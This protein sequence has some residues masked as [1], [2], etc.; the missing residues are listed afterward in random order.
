MPP[1]RNRRN[2]KK[3]GQQQR[4]NDM[5]MRPASSSRGVH[6][7]DDNKNVPITITR[8]TATAADSNEDDCP[9]LERIPGSI[10]AAASSSS[11]SA[12]ATRSEPYIAMAPAPRIIIPIARLGEKKDAS[13]LP[14]LEMNLATASGV[15]VISNEAVKE[16]GLRAVPCDPVVVQE[17]SGAIACFSTAVYLDVVGYVFRF[18][19]LDKYR[20]GSGAHGQIGQDIIEHIVSISFPDAGQSMPFELA[21]GQHLMIRSCIL[22]PSSRRVMYVGPNYFVVPQMHV[23]PAP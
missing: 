17:R 12:A 4:N 6:H 5:H 16:F 22:P 21:N 20:P 3:G 15:S 10:T 19:V 7:D 11:S 18:F 9:D 13:S 1:R 14:C 2:R 23:S 8:M